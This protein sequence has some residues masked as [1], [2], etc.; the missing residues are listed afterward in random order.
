MDFSAISA[1]INSQAT[2]MAALE[3]K[4][5]RLEKV[6]KELLAKVEILESRESLAQKLPAA[7]DFCKPHSDFPQITALSKG[8]DGLKKETGPME[9]IRLE[10]TRLLKRLNNAEAGLLHSAKKRR[11]LDSYC[12][13]PRTAL[14]NNA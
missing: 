14:E 7:S 4:V 3:A 11:V 5:K 6:E 2:K 1:G 9:K 10:N 12:V 13:L 8:V